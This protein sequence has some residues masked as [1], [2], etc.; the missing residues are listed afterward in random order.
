MASP[1]RKITLNTVK[2][3][4]TVFTQYPIGVSG[5]SET[6]KTDFKKVNWYL[7]KTSV[8]TRDLNTATV[9]SARII[10]VASVLFGTKRP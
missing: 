6:L 3:T 9:L 10:G 1:L 4:D 7:N 5:I 8:N 2:N